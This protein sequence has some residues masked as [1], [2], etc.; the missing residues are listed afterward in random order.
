MPYTRR[1]LLFAVLV[2]SSFLGTGRAFEQAAFEAVSR[3]DT[4]PRENI[5]GGVYFKTWSLFLVC[6]QDWPNS[7]KDDGYYV[8]QLYRDFEQFGKAI[9]DDN[10]AVWFWKSRQVVNSHL[11]A[12]IDLER[13]NRFCEAFK[14]NS[15]NGPYLVVTST[16]PDES[17]LSPGLPPDSALFELGNMKPSEL[18]ALLNQVGKLVIQKGAAVT[19][20]D[21]TA[22]APATWGVRLLESVQQVLTSFGCAWT[23]K[24]DAGAA[25][26]E[27]HP[28]SKG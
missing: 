21:V 20:P 23:F 28:C 1:P 8:Y 9:G 6:G 3:T 10:L 22:K 13:S 19:N 15:A 7:N 18:S 12:N 4:I 26:A 14:L 24:I 16:Y 11:A 5:E 17:H 25:K 27:L 2:V